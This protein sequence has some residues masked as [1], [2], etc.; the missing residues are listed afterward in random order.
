[1]EILVQEM[2]RPFGFQVKRKFISKKGKNCIEYV[3]EDKV[4]F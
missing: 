1:M 4:L 3:K 2:K